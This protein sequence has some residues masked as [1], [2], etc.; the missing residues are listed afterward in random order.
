M[1]VGV[2]VGMVVGMVVGLVVGVV[3]GVVV[4]VVVDVGV[5]VSMTSDVD[6]C[7]GGAVGLGRGPR[8]I[9]GKNKGVPV[10]PAAIISA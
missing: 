5:N 9:N 3:V 1:V 10:I 8:T 2:V 4:D 6:V 7:M